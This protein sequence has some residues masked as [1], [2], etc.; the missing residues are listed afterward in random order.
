MRT[1]QQAAQTDGEQRV[2]YHT[3]PKGQESCEKGCSRRRSSPDFFF[4]SC[5]LAPAVYDETCRG[6]CGTRRKQRRSF[7]KEDSCSP[8]LSSVQR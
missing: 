7:T 6:Q 4:K 8:E 5:P 3:P 1:E 2:G